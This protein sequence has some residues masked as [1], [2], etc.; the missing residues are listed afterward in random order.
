MADFKN[1]WKSVNGVRE[2][3]Y[4]RL[5]QIPKQ[6]QAD[7]SQVFPQTLKYEGLQYEAQVTDG[8]AW[9]G[10]VPQSGVL[11]G[12]KMGISA[13]TLSKY[14]GRQATAQDMMAVT[15]D[16]A[17]AIAKKYYWDV[18][19]ADGINNQAIAANFFDS[20]WGSGGYGSRMMRQ[21]LN[22]TYGSTVANGSSTTMAITPA[23]LQLINNADQ[24]ALFNNF[25]NIRKQFIQGLSGY[26]TY[27]KGWLNR[28]D[29]I[30]NTYIGSFGTSAKAVMAFAKKNMVAIIGVSVGIALI[31]TLFIE[32]ATKKQSA[33]VL[34]T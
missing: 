12:S 33:P 7:F 23:E 20:I 9:S 18:I 11:V 34:A 1:I 8:G 13:P 21:A 24:A 17:Q 28:L 5:S 3:E 10:G 26:A 29:S 25:M 2:L 4:K 15:Q 31:T 6:Y 30:Y 27:G 32:L 19:L 22:Q 16:A 14:L